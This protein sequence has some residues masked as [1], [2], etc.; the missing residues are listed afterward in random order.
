MLK[1]AEEKAQ[2]RPCNIQQYFTAIIMFILR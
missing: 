1:E 2:I